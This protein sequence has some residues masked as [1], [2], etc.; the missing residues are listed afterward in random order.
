MQ[1]HTILKSVVAKYADAHVLCL[2]GT[3]GKVPGVAEEFVVLGLAVNICAFLSDY[4]T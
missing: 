4:S 2:G 3:P 1:A